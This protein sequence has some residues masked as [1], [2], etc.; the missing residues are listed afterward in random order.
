MWDQRGCGPWRE[1]FWYLLLTNFFTIVLKERF[2]TASN[3]TYHE[4]CYIWSMSAPTRLTVLLVLVLHFHYSL[5][6][7]HCGSADNDPKCNFLFYNFF[8]LT[9]RY[10][11]ILEDIAADDHVQK[12]NTQY[13]G[14]EIGWISR[15]PNCV[16]NTTL[17]ST[18]GKKP[19]EICCWKW[20]EWV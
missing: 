13:W 11:N 20:E 16:C 9:L 14:T 7:F 17:S 3:Y 8:Q 15:C 18:V 4:C 1:L 2:P 19:I 12:T 10:L 6:L 5:S